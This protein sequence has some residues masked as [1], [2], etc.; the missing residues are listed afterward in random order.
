M[1][2]ASSRGKNSELQV[3]RIDLQRNTKQSGADAPATFLKVRWSCAGAQDY[4][5]RNAKQ[6]Y[7]DAQDRFWVT[8]C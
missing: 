2:D 5:H 3:R 7:A 1:G 8:L 6:S 4:L